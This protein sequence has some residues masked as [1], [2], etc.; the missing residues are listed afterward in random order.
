M[1]PC[2]LWSQ[3]GLQFLQNRKMQLGHHTFSRSQ[4][5]ERA[6]AVPPRSIAWHKSAGRPSGQAQQSFPPAPQM[7]RRFAASQ[8]H[9]R[10]ESQVLRPFNLLEHRVAQ[11]NT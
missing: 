1:H 10:S 7:H 2:L 8:Q 5:A 9:R 11:S 6:A 4:R 3:A